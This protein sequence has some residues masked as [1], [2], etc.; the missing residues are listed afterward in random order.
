MSDGIAKGTN[1]PTQKLP[2]ND[3]K[4]NRRATAVEALQKAVDE[5]YALAKGRKGAEELYAQVSQ[6]I[7]DIAKWRV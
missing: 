2:G 5:L 7:E 3:P 1:I 4:L 6:H